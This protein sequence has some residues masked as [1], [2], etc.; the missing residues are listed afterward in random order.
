MKAG[1]RGAVVA[2]L[3]MAGS[4]HADISFNL[5]NTFA[6]QRP[7]GTDTPA[8]A[9]YQIFWSA[10]SSY[11]MTGNDLDISVSQAAVGSQIP[12][13]DDYV[14]AAG[15]VGEPGGFFF[16]N[17]NF[18]K[19]DADVGNPVGGISSGYVYGF[20]YQDSTPDVGDFFGRSPIFGNTWA[21]PNQNPAPAPDGVDFAPTQDIVLDTYKVVPEPG[22]MALL[23]LGALT[24]AASRKFRKKA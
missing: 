1:L 17:P 22:T 19:T 10:D 9:F 16:N 23:G 13:F 12:V 2:A 21:D 15:S 7:L 6:F 3:V 4:A 24:L 5:F 20:I 8:N 18:T 14:L 11:A